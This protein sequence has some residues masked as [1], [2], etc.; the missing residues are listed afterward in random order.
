MHALCVVSVWGLSFRRCSFQDLAREVA[1]AGAKGKPDADI[2]LQLKIQH[3]A[4]AALN[5]WVCLFARLEPI[6][7]L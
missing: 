7:S 3:E 5:S 2:E 4:W 1:K 6:I